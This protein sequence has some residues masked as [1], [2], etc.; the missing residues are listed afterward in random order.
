M[1]FNKIG[2]REKK[3]T[4]WLGLQNFSI[5]IALP[6]FKVRISTHSAYL[7]LMREKI[8]LVDSQLTE[9]EKF[10][11]LFEHRHK[12]SGSSGTQHA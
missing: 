1:N 7:T 8:I 3:I 11:T 10:K 2:N 6:L 9:I 4:E 5:S 12:S